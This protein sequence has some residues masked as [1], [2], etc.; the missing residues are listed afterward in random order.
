MWKFLYPLIACIKIQSKR[1]VG[2][3]LQNF[4]VLSKSIRWIKNCK[5]WKQNELLH[6]GLLMFFHVYNKSTTC[7]EWNNANKNPIIVFSL[8]AN[9][10]T[11]LV[12]HGKEVLVDIKES[13]AKYLSLG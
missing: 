8:C 7:N 2:Q 6:W 5:V 12:S 1:F 4:W 10:T 3:Y 9:S 11:L 13:F